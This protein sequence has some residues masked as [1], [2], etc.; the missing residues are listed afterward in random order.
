MLLYLNQ[1]SNANMKLWA[2]LVLGFSLISGVFA[3]NPS[4]EKLHKYQAL[5]RSGSVDLDSAA[6]EEVTSTPRDY[7]TAVILTARDARY[8][9]LMCREFDSE[10]DLI[11]RSW[12]KGSKS[13]G[14]NMVFGTVDFD[15][16]KAVFQKV[17]CTNWNS[18]ICAKM[19]DEMK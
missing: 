12:N 13:D 3:A 15:R 7:F 17:Y 11:A 1:A 5:A 14:L 9:C 2:P 4:A 8:G 19:A 6:F 16:G 18:T 10:W